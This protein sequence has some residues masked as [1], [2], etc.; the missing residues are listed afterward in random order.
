M[1]TLTFAY[2]TNGHLISR[3]NV[4]DSFRTPCVAVPVL[5]YDKIGENGDFTAPLTYTLEACTLGEII[6]QSLNWTKKVPL[7]DKN[8]HRE[9]WGMRP[10]A[11][12][13]RENL[14]LKQ[15]QVLAVLDS[16][17]KTEAEVAAATGRRAGRAGAFLLALESKGLA[18]FDLNKW[19][20]V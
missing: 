12:A 5:D 1:R 8:R 9:F 7:A 14:P 20:A 3:L 18:T 16:G 4:D 13:S 19:K 11:P 6:G 10:L 17:P 2:D 15:A